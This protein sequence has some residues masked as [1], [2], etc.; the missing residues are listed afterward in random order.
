MISAPPVA[1]A[2]RHADQ[3]G[4]A[5]ADAEGKR[6]Q[7]ELQPHADAVARQRRRAEAS[8]QAGDQYGGE[9]RRRRRGRAHQADAQDFAKQPRL[10]A[11]AREPRREPQPAAPHRAR[12][13]REREGRGGGARDHQ[14]DQAEARRQHERQADI[15]ERRADA[16][17]AR[18]GAVARAAQQRG[19][20]AVRPDQQRG[21]EE[22]VA[23]AQRLGEHVAAAAHQPEQRRQGRP[24][25][26]HEDQRQAPAHQQGMQHQHAGILVPAGTE[27]AGQ[28]RGDSAAHAAVRHVEHQRHERH[29]QHEARQ[30]LGAEA[31]DDPGLGDGDA[32]LQHHQPGRGAGQPPQRGPDGRGQKRMRRQESSGERAQT[33]ALWVA[34]GR[35]GGVSA[36]PCRTIPGTL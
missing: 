15:D 11:H 36:D 23:E 4:E 31:A 24:A 30:R 14:P 9:D 6:R 20:E 10:Q 17:A 7:H 18:R 13:Q 3:R 21:G 35:S 8:D 29:D 32:D 33:S 19:E 1:G 2:G 27:R 22:P 5:G 26:H 16:D 34:E 12:L 28:R 25:E